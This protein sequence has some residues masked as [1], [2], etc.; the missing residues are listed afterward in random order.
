[1][2]SRLRKAAV[3]VCRK[4]PWNVGSDFDAI[5]R[6][7]RC[8]RQAFG[9]AVT[10]LGRPQVTAAAGLVIAPSRRAEASLR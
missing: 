1:M 6:F 7:D 9:Q 10:A 4:S 8:Y 5:E 3:Q 2:I